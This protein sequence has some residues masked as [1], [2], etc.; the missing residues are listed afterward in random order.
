MIF[1]DH[2]GRV[3]LTTKHGFQILGFHVAVMKN[4]GA[5]QMVIGWD[6]A[7][8]SRQ[9]IKERCEACHRWVKTACH[10][11]AGYH[12]FGPWDYACE[13]LLFPERYR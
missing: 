8:R 7:W 13:Q 11:T 6:S 2:S 5:L 3:L 9:E 12:E 10:G 1:R 4:Q